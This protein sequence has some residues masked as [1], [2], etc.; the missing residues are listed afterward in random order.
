MGHEFF[1]LLSCLGAAMK[2][3]SAIKR[4]FPDCREVRRPWKSPFPKDTKRLLSLILL[5]HKQKENLALN[6]LGNFK[7]GRVGGW[8]LS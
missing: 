3:L 1:A 2:R 8:S 6:H 5:L 4:G 7:V